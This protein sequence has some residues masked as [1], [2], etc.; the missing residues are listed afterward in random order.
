MKAAF[1]YNNR[2]VRVQEA[3]VPK[4]KDGEMLVRIEASGLCGSDVMEWYRIKK[5]PLVL[6]HEIAG[7][8]VEA[9]A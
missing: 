6:G 1:Y 7:T 2:D 5:A 9:G 3:P 4:I 8:V